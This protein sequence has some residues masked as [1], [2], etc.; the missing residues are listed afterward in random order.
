MTLL[1]PEDHFVEF[2]CSTF[3]VGQN[4]SGGSKID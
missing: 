2:R 3:D 4:I 1:T